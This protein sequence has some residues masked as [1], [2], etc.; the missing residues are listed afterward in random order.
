MLA[1]CQ[2]ARVCNAYLLTLSTGQWGPDGMS[3]VS[4]F[5]H[6]RLKAAEKKKKR[7]IGWT[8]SKTVMENVVVFRVICNIK[9]FDGEGYLTQYQT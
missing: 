3:V 5:D 2:P 4:L 1:S 6:W 9:G 7:S 8:I